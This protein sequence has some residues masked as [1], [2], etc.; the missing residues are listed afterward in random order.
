M[1]DGIV[2]N[3]PVVVETDE[4]FDDDVDV[5]LCTLTLLDAS[6][7][8]ERKVEEVAV[9]LVIKTERAYSTLCFAAADGTLEVEKRS[10]FWLSRLL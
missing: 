5:G 8:I 9:G 4:K 3:G 6:G 10:R 2:I 1:P 7:L